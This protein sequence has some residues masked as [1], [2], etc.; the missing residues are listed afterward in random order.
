MC[1]EGT[2]KEGKCDECCGVDCSVDYGCMLEEGKEEGRAV[3]VC[4]A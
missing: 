4:P 1:N 3:E 2:A